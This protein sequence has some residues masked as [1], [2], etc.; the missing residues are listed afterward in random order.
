MDPQIDAHGSPSRV[1]SGATWDPLATASHQIG[2]VASNEACVLRISDW[3][4]NVPHFETIW[5]STWAEVAPKWDH[6]WVQ[7]GPKLGPCCRS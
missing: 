3:T 1:Q 5:A 4:G 7:V 6:T 2:N